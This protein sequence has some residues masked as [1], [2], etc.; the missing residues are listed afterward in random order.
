M[1]FKLVSFFYI[2]HVIVSRISNCIPKITHACCALQSAVE[3]AFSCSS[4]RRTS[5]WII[6]ETDDR[7]IPPPHVK[8]FCLFRGSEVCLPDSAT[9]TQLCRRFHQYAHCVCCCPDACWLFRTSPAA[10]WCCSSSNLCSVTLLKTVERRNLYIHTDFWS[11]FCLLYWTASKLP[12]LLD[13]VSKFA[14]FSVS[15]LKDEKLIKKQT[16][17][18]QIAPLRPLYFSAF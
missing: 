17:T 11:K 18:V 15:D 3:R 6:H 1:S 7:W 10:C 13:R 8:F 5:L 9:A 2:Y 14:L 4:L 12:R 16:V